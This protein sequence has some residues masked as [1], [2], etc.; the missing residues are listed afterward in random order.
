M[1]QPL[2]IL[3]IL[4]QR[5]D[6]TGSG[7][8]LQAMLREAAAAGH[9]NYL[10]AGIQSGRP[11]ELDCIDGD[12]CGFLS[13]G[14]GDIAHPIVGMSDVMPY[15]SSRFC[16]LSDAEIDDYEAAFGRRIRAAV[17]RFDPQIIHSH[18]LWIVSSL[19]RRLYP[20]LPMVTTCHGTDL[21]Q[22]Q[23][24]PH[25]QERVLSGCRRVDAAMALSAA[26]K[27]DIVNLYGLSSENVVVTGAGYDER[28]FHLGR[29][30]APDPVR[31]VYAGKLAH[32][33]G[34][35]WL[36][37]ALRHIDSPQWRL[38]LVGGGSGA[39]KEDCLAL[40]RGLGE[41]VV[42]HGPLPQAQ[43]AD[44]M[45][46]S[47][48][49][50]LPSLFEG[51]PLVLLESLSCGCRIVANDLP[52]VLAILGDLRAE[53]IHLVRTPRLHNLETP[54]EA[55]EQCFEKDWAEALQMQ[56]DAAR[57]VPR[58]DLSAIR[59]RLASYTWKGIFGK[60]EPLYYRVLRQA[61]E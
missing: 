21:R 45:R 28:L 16:D 11:V 53:Y 3:H 20:D 4:S 6:S 8:Y 57:R 47:H 30:P 29:K 35:P 34:L 2:K 27:E 58:L 38:H 39:E 7:I 60:V 1:K 59:D 43:L 37:R 50:V 41:R 44:I 36:L 33:K 5:P 12:R 14:A 10:V 25:L 46:R 56:I 17:T 55:D 18:H 51:L 32:A 40:A 22:F 23:N 24:C 13:F 26:Q 9:E 19:T 15:E 42:V 31:L 54:V 61:V 48:I 49:F 52:G